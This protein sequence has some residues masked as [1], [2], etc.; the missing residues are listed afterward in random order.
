ME[1]EQNRL[2][3]KRSN[4][5]FLGRN[6]LSTLRNSFRAEKVNS[7]SVR[8]NLSDHNLQGTYM[9]VTTIPTPTAKPVVMRKKRFSMLSGYK[10]NRHSLA[11]GCEMESVKKPTPLIR[12]R[13][14]TDK[15]TTAYR[16][17]RTQLSSAEN[18]HRSNSSLMS[19][20]STVAKSTKTA[21]N[22]AYHNN[23]GSPKRP[24][25]YTDSYCYRFNRCYEQQLA[26]PTPTQRIIPVSSTTVRTKVRRG[27][28]SF[29]GWDNFAFNP[30]P[31]HRR[32][33]DKNANDK[34][35]SNGRR[36]TTSMGLHSCSS[37]SFI[38]TDEV[39]NCVL[40]KY[41]SLNSDFNTWV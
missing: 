24:L 30:S 15:N 5:G 34:G 41:R 38:H 16:V 3:E 22:Q 32:T 12:R 11:A 14:T 20:H 35:K 13:S 21:I 25:P 6:R 31:D 37:E 28:N 39:S 4:S 26:Q 29:Q 33:G 7:I 18:L 10:S 2:R 1:N 23:Q 9:S 27:R 17:V 19:S 8:R 36:R 40:T